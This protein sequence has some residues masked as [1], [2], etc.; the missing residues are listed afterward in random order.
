MRSPA[1]FWLSVALNLALAAA[2][3]REGCGSPKPPAAPGPLTVRTQHLVGPVRVVR[4]N[5]YVQTQPFTWQQIESGDYFTYVENLRAIGCPQQ[6]IRDI[7]LA[8]VNQL[9]A[10]RR[11]ATVQTEYDQWWRSEPDLDVLEAAVS[12]SEELEKERRVLLTQLLGPGWESADP[13]MP[14]VRHLGGPHLTGATLSELPADTEQAVR[15]GWTKLHQAYAAYQQERSAAG[16]PEDPLVVAQMRRE[17]REQLERLLTGEQLEEFLLRNSR[18]SE[19][20]RTSLEGFDTTPEEFRAIF[21]ALDGADR[22]LMYATVTT[23]ESYDQQQQQ[24]TQQADA[25]L[26]RALGQERFAEYKLNVDPVYRDVRT[27]AEDVGA[28]PETV[29]P[30]YEIQRVRAQEEAV[31]RNDPNLSAEQRVAALQTMREQTET[32]IRQLI[33]QEAYERYAKSRGGQ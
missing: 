20:L 27:L 21:R 16:K 29:L 31:I 33:G 30:L 32:A 8:D 13:T 23:P 4:T 7:I 6:T 28:A 14:T 2:L 18:V 19:Q 12:R 1:L 25:A 5:I 11:A 24:L 9:F 15:Q 3:L 22:Q 10:R 17:H 26:E